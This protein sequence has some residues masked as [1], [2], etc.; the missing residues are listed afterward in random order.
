M[1]YL[2]EPAEVLHRELIAALEDQ[3]FSYNPLRMNWT[4]YLA[5]ALGQPN[6]YL[7][8]SEGQLLTELDAAYGGALS[9][10]RVSIAHLVDDVAAN[11]GA[12]GG[13]GSPNRIVFNGQPV[14]FNSNP[15][16]YTPP[17]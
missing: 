13:G 2:T 3:G 14:V 5:T 16:V 7:F 11:I 4:E 15:I 1:S 17:A 6:A 9:H 8:K 12:G 10:L